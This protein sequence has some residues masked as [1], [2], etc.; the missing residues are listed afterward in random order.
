M[1]KGET[2]EEFIEKFKPKLT[3]DDCYTP[4]NIY[5][6][7]AG[8]VAEEY[9]VDRGKMLRPFWPGADYQAQEY[10]EGCVVVD[11]P[12]FSIL[13]KIVDW[14]MARGVRFFLFA[15]ALTLFAGGRQGVCG[16]RLRDGDLPKRRGGKHQLFDQSGPGTGADG[17][18]TAPADNG[19]KPGKRKSAEQANAEILFSG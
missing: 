7:V 5:E 6:A 8:W 17:A 1:A 18:G 12:P 11:N 2:Y 4:E 15:P 3:T 14:Y 10:P 9:G 13:V 16:V 19:G